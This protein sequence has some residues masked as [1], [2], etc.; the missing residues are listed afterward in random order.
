VQFRQTRG[1]RGQICFRM[2]SSEGMDVS[3]TGAGGPPAIKDVGAAHPIAGAWRPML[4]EVVH[5]FVRGDYR[6]TRRVPGVD[7]VSAEAAEHIRASVVRYGATLIDLPN[8]TWHTSAAQWYGTDWDLLVDLWTAEEEPSDLVLQGRIAS[9]PL[10]LRRVVRN[11]PGCY[12]CE[13]ALR[14]R[15]SRE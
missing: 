13:A 3:D 2:T 9:P 4:R 7:P 14:F 8:D 15:A 11:V 10:A 6:L 5:R 12:Y 1:L